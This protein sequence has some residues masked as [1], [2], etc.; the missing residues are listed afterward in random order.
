MMRGGT[1]RG[2]FF[3]AKDLPVDPQSRDEILI[4][5]IGSGHPLQ[6]DGIGGA[7]AVTSKVAIVS[8][9]SRPGVDVDYL[10][11]Q[12]GVGKRFVDTSPNC[13]NMLS[14]VGPFAIESGLVRATD[15]VTI[16]RTYNVNA[17]SEIE[18]EVLTSGGVVAYAGAAKIDGVPGTAAPVMLIFLDA[19][20]RSHESMF[21]T[22]LARERISGIET[23][24]INAAMPMMILRASDIG[25]TGNESTQDLTENTT[26][27]ARLEEMR[28]EVGR[29]MGLGDV[30]EKLFRNLCSSRRLRRMTICLCAIYASQ[31]SSD[32]RHD[33]RN[34]P[35]DG[36][37]DQRNGGRTGRRSSYPVI[38]HRFRASDG[39][40]GC[41]HAPA[42]G[43]A[44]RQPL[45]HRAPP[46]RRTHHGAGRHRKRPKASGGCGGQNGNACPYMTPTD[47]ELRCLKGSPWRALPR[48]RL[49]A[50]RRRPD[51]P[52]AERI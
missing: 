26:L 49:R 5:A 28:R 6:I 25:V 45:A 42:R 24:C 7:N 29:R 47:A 46:V 48:S 16:I 37:H 8:R 39:P 10:F 34:R 30:S 21:P 18:A 43:P 36:G 27:L 44:C 52:S 33:R 9:S 41:R 20:A 35:C 19:S 13:G 15:P 14:A 32:P 31:L 12:V 22:G 23:T 50:Q 2:P 3:L 4:S 38:G 17:R 1:S 11:A 40:F 51:Q